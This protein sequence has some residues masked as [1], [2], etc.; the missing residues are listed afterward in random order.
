MNSRECE[1]YLLSKPETEKTFPFGPEVAVFKVMNKMFATLALAKDDDVFWMNLKCDP[2]EAAI[3]RDIFAAVKPGYHMN[4]LHWNTIV[5]NGSVPEG[6]L[7][8]MIDNSYALVA[9]GLLKKHQ[10][11]LV[12]LYGEEL[13]K[14]Y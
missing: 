8:R 12:T 6:E 14:T 1:A 13:L 5:L 11:R 2:Q 4:K 9:Q 3:L 7:K 10:K